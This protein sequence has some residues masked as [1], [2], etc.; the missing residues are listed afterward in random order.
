MFL[1][2]GGI[3]LVQAVGDGI[4]KIFK[5]GIIFRIEVLFLNKFPEAFNEIQ[6]SS[7]LAMASL[8]LA[9]GCSRKYSS[10]VV[11]CWLISLEG[12]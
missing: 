4:F 8:T 3:R 7:I 2:V 1:F 6:I 5:P 10:I 9:G 11:L 12:W